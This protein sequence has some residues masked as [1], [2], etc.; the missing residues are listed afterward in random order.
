MLKYPMAKLVVD[1]GGQGLAIV[2]DM[3]AR[4]GLPLEAADKKG[5]LSNYAFLNNAL[6][7]GTFKA[8]HTT[9][10]AQD[11]NILQRDDNRSTPDKTIVKGHS[12]AVDAC[13]Y[14]FK[15]S[16]AYAHQAP[17][18]QPKPGTKEYED[19]QAQILYDHHVNRLQ[20]ERELKDGQGLNWELDANGVPPWLKYSE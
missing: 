6:R 13:L 12:D 15:F 11:C 14:A 1:A 7:T 8:K 10:F 20:K 5:K 17:A 2:E 3:K 18:N 4:H 9:M 16:P 19:Q